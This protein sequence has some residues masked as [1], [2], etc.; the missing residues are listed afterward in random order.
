MWDKDQTCFARAAILEHGYSFLVAGTQTCILLEIV[1]GLLEL[2]CGGEMHCG[3]PRALEDLEHA[4]VLSWNGTWKHR[5]H[6][7]G[8]G[9]GTPRELEKLTNQCE[10]SMDNSGTVGRTIGE[11]QWSGLAA[12]AAAV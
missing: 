5:R 6:S 1:L 8:K 3:M 12:A 11:Q 10:E 9:V 7:S 2:K 4:R